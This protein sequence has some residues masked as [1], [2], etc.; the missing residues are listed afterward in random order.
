MSPRKSKTN[1]KH[2]HPNQKGKIHTNINHQQKNHFHTTKINIKIVR[3][4]KRIKYQPTR[5][6][7]LIKYKTTNKFHI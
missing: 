5:E 7:K 2:R 1:H 3:N 4:Y 6:E